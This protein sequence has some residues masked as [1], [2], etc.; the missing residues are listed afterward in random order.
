M[1]LNRKMLI[2]S[3][4]L[5]EIIDIFMSNKILKIFQK[6]KYYFYSSY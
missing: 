4:W 1:E 5:I 6:I 2:K 3:K